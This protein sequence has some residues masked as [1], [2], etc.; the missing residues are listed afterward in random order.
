[1]QKIVL[2]NRVKNPAYFDLCGRFPEDGCEGL[3]LVGDRA[4]AYIFCLEW[5]Q[6]NP[7]R[8][9]IIIDMPTGHHPLL[10][11]KCIGKA[12]PAAWMF[13]DIAD[14]IWLLLGY[15]EPVEEPE[16]ER[17]CRQKP[18]VWWHEFNFRQ[19]NLHLTP[20]IK[21]PPATDWLKEEWQLPHRYATIQP[22]FDARYDTYR[23]QSPEF[24]EEI[25][26]HIAPKIPL[27]VVGDPVNY[28]KMR[29]HPKAY[30]AWARGISVMESLSMIAGASMHIGGET[31][32]TIWASIMGVN[33]YG[34]YSDVTY[35]NWLADPLA[36][37]GLVRIGR[38]LDVPST[39]EAIEG[40]WNVETHID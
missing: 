26:A 12:C 33:V 4:T 34:V 31:G 18:W 13:Q 19:G 30:S 32:T 17:L 24:W 29:T 39:C 10:S 23:N 6:A 2:N 38:S 8:K 20:T 37:G 36:F 21:P 35:E 22:L 28:S 15:D 16:G 9:L 7:D 14:E 25:V 5:R 27:V 40:F 11:M 1:M 3:F